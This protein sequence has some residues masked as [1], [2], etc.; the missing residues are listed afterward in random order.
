[1]PIGNDLAKIFHNAKHSCQIERF[2]EY[3]YNVAGQVTVSEPVVVFDDLSGQKRSDQ[4][5]IKEFMEDAAPEKG[6]RK[7]NYRSS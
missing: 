7:K 4:M 2:K 6:V 3:F 1:M 5:V